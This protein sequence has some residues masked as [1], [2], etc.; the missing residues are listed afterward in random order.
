M[1]ILE[2]GFWSMGFRIFHTI[3]NFAKICDQPSLLVDNF[4][5]PS[6]PGQFYRI[7]LFAKWVFCVPTD[8][9]R[10]ICSRRTNWTS[11]NDHFQSWV[12]E[13]AKS[14][15]KARHSRRQACSETEEEMDISAR[16]FLD[17]FRMSTSTQFWFLKILKIQPNSEKKPRY[18]STH[19][20]I[21]TIP[22]RRYP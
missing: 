16:H 3:S 2:F 8:H 19:T 12:A 14:R 5:S 20:C 13:G 21:N 6:L 1:D 15:R 10:T 22:A 18:D 17:F 11:P 7:I 9:R 4:P